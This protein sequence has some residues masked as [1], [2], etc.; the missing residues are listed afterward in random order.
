MFAG[1][2][3]ARRPPTDKSLATG[4]NRDATCGVAP[5]RLILMSLLALRLLGGDM[6]MLQ[7][8]AWTG[9]IVSRTAERGVAAAVESTFEGDEPC[10]LCKAV[11]AVQQSEKEPRP[12]NPDSLITKLKLKDM[13]RSEDLAIASLTA[14][15]DDSSAPAMAPA[16][17]GLT[18]SDAPPVPPPRIN[19]A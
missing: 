19:V 14:F 4:G 17:R 16:P 9:M 10:P 12:A 2:F 13:L 3:K 7:V 15:H 8:V 11:K 6:A 5:F 1:R 18:R